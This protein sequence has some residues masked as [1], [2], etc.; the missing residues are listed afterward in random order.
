MKNLFIH[1]FIIVLILC[2]CN[3]FLDREPISSVTPEVY[4]STEAELATYSAAKYSHFP[5]H[6]TWD[7]GT[8]LIDNNSDNQAG[9]AENNNFIP[10]EIRVP[11]YSGAWDF[12]QIR[13]CNYFISRANGK[14]SNGEISGV[15]ANI[16]HYIGEMYFFRA[17]LYFQKLMS[18]GD[19]PIIKQ[20]LTDNYDELTEANQRRPRNEVARFILSDLDSAFLLMSPTPPAAN[21]LTKNVALLYKSRVALYEGTW[22]KYH[23]GTSRVPK[24]P[25][26]PG[27]NA[28]Y[29]KDFSIDL[30]QEITFFLNEAKTAASAIADAIQLGSYETM[31]NSDDLSSMN[32]VL[33]WKKNDLSFQVYHYLQATL[34]Q[35]SPD[36]LSNSGGNMGYTRSLVE[37]FLME[38]GLP[39]YHAGSGYQGDETLENVVANRDNRLRISISIPGDPINPLLNFVKP[40][41]LLI[42]ENRAVTGYVNRKGLDITN[43][44]LSQ[45]PCITASVIFRAAEAYLNYIEADY[46]LNQSLDAKSQNYWKALRQRAGVDEDFQKTINATDLSMEN[47][48][49][50]YSG[51][52]MI[53]QTLYNIRR[54]RRCEFIAEGMRK[55]DLYRWRSLDRM[56]DYIVEG[57][58]LWDENYKLYGEELQPQGETG[59]TDPNVSAKSNKYLCP[60]RIRENNRAFNGY[61][62]MKAHYLDPIGYSNF[63]LS[64]PVKGDDPST[65]VIY[66][67]PGWDIETGSTA[68]E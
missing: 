52:Q 63:R 53:D 2:S 21:R 66:Q 15:D 40:G 3:D 43:V 6:S 10:G 20:V 24:G 28:G 61:T 22:L 50:V 58:N 54:E 41:I 30:N 27:A 11:E 51:D 42:A 16:R 29:L 62:F 39:F 65:S 38:N 46:V 13:D 68:K 23:A 67:N 19:F 14:Y 35:T 48:L 12:T 64:T 55:N 44:Y 9:S 60:Y 56:K 57:F 7:I 1:S 37:S 18:V 49:A 5:A 59:V 32:E 17:Y 36:A 4:L 25:G 8:F 31:F 26:W 34:H 47:D 45:A 33:L